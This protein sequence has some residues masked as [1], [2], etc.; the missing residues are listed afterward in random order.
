MS[1]E[2]LHLLRLALPESAPANM[3]A[4]FEILDD[5]VEWDYV[6][7]FPEVVTYHGPS[8]VREFL[9]GWADAFDDFTVEA[10]EA[11]DAGDRVAVH[12][13]QRGRGKQT[14]AEVDNRVWQVF[15]F[16]G[17]KIVH[18]HGYATR[19]EAVEAVGLRE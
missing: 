19:A 12:V 15:T 1:Q 7:A 3:D 11:I 17:R 5:D 4:L 14:G 10:G 6:G 16:R 18:C 2:N 13:H 9:R 8:G